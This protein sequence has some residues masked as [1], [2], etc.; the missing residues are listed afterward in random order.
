MGCILPQPITP[1]QRTQA[2]SCRTAGGGT[3]QSNR[4]RRKRMKKLRKER[5]LDVILLLFSVALLCASAVVTYTWY[6]SELRYSFKNNIEATRDLQYWAE[7]PEDY[8]RYGEAYLDG[9]KATGLTEDDY[10][11]FWAWDQHDRNTVGWYMS[12]I[13]STITRG[14]DTITW[15]NGLYYNKTVSEVMGD[16]YEEK[17]DELRANTKATPTSTFERALM[18]KYQ[19]IFLFTSWVFYP[20][21]VLCICVAYRYGNHPYR[22]SFWF[23]PDDNG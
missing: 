1:I 16:V 15:K 20:V 9:I 18:V 13:E 19:P 6:T 4:T 14:Y 12:Y 21:G 22:E 7:T 11:Q 10:T 23:V 2:P 8:V 3:S 5:T 17:M